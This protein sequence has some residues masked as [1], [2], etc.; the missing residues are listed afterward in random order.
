M[1]RKD[2]IAIAGIIRKCKHGIS[3]ASQEKLAQEFCELFLFDNERFDSEK[4][5]EACGF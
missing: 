1:S 3:T 4:F 5:L 2:Y